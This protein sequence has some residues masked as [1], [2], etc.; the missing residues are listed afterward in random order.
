MLSIGFEL[1]ADLQRDLELG[2][3]AI[4]DAPG[5]FDYFEL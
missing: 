3:L 2:Y 1:E 4:D 5:G